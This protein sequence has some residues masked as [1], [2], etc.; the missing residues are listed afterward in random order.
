MTTKPK[1]RPNLNG[2]AHWPQYAK[3]ND[4]FASRSRRLGIPDN[5]KFSRRELKILGVTSQAAANRWLQYRYGMIPAYNDLI[6][7][8]DDLIIKSDE[9]QTYS[10]R[11]T[12]PLGDLG[13]AAHSS[14]NLRV[15]EGKGEGFQQVK[16]WFNATNPRV[17][18]LA[19]RGLD[20][21]SLPSIAWELTP[22]SFMVDW[23]YP[24]GDSLE[25]LSATRGLS[26]AYGYKSQ[27]YE[28]KDGKTHWA[29]ASEGGTKYSS[30]VDGAA[31]LSYGAFQRVPITSFPLV[32]FPEVENPFGIH[33]GQRITD[34]L[35]IG[36]QLF[37][38][39]RTYHYT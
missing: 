29:V 17:R 11:V 28:V 13:P 9:P 2:R 23:F 20:I 6:K 12:I 21:T 27:K 38:N 3:M 16:V 4:D 19:Q 35:A 22:F 36:K 10:A 32:R 24:V 1:G 25:A 7:I 15:N 34:V 8:F 14:N 39:K 5:R 18:S 37:S 31:K 26:F 30:S 33:T